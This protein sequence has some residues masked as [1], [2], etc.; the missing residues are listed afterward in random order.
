MP[1]CRLLEPNDILMFLPCFFL[2]GF[3]VSAVNPVFG[4]FGDFL[5]FF[6]RSFQVEKNQNASARIHFLPLARFPSLQESEWGAY[7]LS[8]FL[9]YLSASC[10]N[11]KLSAA[12][13]PDSSGHFGNRRAH[14]N[15][16]ETV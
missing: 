7:G 9:R 8:I 6:L 3:G 13:P 14:E 5:C 11:F 16:Y 15:E 1:G 10:R 2:G 4:V 12:L